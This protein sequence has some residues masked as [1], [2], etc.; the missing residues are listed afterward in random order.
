MN[1][2]RWEN[3]SNENDRVTRYDYKYC[4]LF[5][6]IKKWKCRRDE[7]ISYLYR[8]IEKDFVDYIQLIFFNNFYNSDFC[9]KFCVSLWKLRRKIDGFAERF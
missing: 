6:T 7:L 9:C 8:K 5:V 1:F 2:L 3:R 4:M